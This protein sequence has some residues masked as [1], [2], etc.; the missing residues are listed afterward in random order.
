MIKNFTRLILFLSLIKSSAVFSQQ[1]LEAKRQEL[2]SFSNRL[3]T[4]FQSN[5]TKAF[6]LAK[7]YN[8]PVFRVEKDGKIIF[9]ARHGRAW[10]PDLPPNRK[11]HYC[12]GNHANH[13]FI[14]RRFFR[15]EFIRIRHHFSRKIRY[16]GRRENLPEPSGICWEK[17][18][19]AGC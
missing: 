19:H 11:Q 15:V 13:G 3:K 6:A 16:L 5:R 4:D 1:I 10:F 9:S 12:G 18:Y 2:I 8:W 7:Q 14:Q 17:G